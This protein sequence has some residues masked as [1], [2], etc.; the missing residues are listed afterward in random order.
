M[1]S[2][3]VTG[4]RPSLVYRS[5]LAYELVMLGLY[6]RHYRARYETIAA[7]IP[8]HASVVEL[9]CGPGILYDRFL[10]PRAVN[11]LGLDINPGFVR[12]LSRRGIQSEVWDLRIERPLPTADY[13]VMQASLYHFLPAA[14]S[15]IAR[16]LAAARKQVIVAEPIRNLASSDIAIVAY[17]ARKLTN[18]GAGASHNRFAERA[19]DD[20]AQ[21]FGDHFCRSF[22][23]PGGR[24]KIYVFDKVSRPQ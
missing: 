10:R 2:A 9:C 8:D 15:I 7:L 18:A 3:R 11:Y 17:I 20:L 23:A 24:E 13:V 4:F 6:G 16:M 5:K 21:R 1:P 12:S 14:H 22:L 19:L